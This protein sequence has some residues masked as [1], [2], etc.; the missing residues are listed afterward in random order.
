MMRKYGYD[1]AAA[2]ALL[3]Q[4]GW[5]DTD[6]NPATPRLA[7]GAAGMADMTSF[8]VTLLT[9]DD[10]E[11]QRLAQLLKDS[12][13][14]CGIQIDIS[15]GPVDQVFAVGPDGPVFGRNFSLAQFAWPVSSRQACSLFTTRAIPGPYPE[16]PQ[17]WGGANASGYSNP[18]FDQ[19]CLA[20]QNSLADTAEFLAANQQAQAVV[21]E[22]LPV[23]PLF[24]RA[25]TAITRPDL[26]NLQPEPANASLYWNLESL[27]YG[28]AC[29]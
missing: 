24:L 23:V 7:L 2:N 18:A 20:A 14:Q 16:Y 26:C 28:G 19:A 12:L 9:G 13:A 17:G 3:Q 21:G 10:P 25:G 5:L 8:V 1:P 6:N 11:H 4:S 29:Q 22:D 15:S 27:D